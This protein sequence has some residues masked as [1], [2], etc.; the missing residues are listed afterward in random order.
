MLFKNYLFNFVQSLPLCKLCTHHLKTDRHR[1]LSPLFSHHN[2]EI[3]ELLFFL[4]FPLRNLFK[5]DSRSNHNWA[6]LSLQA[7]NCIFQCF[8]AI[9]R[10]QAWQE[11]PRCGQAVSTDG[12]QDSKVSM[13]VIS[14]RLTAEII[15]LPASSRTTLLSLRYGQPTAFPG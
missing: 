10:R 12:Y 15:L 9:F 11:T 2:W 3:H 4:N 5:P 14:S 6:A 8:T 7:M 1:E 13:V